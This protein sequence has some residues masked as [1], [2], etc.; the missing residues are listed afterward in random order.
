[1]LH[2]ALDLAVE[3]AADEAAARRVGDRVTVAEALLAVARMGPVAAPG[4]GFTQDPLE[5]RVRALL[6]GA[7]AGREPWR[8]TGAALAGLAVTLLALSPQFHHGLETLLGHL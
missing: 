6:A 2:E 7:P 8:G 1:M 4:P 3:R 5:L